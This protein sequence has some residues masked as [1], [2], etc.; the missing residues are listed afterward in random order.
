MHKINL[1]LVPHV[2]SEKLGWKIQT[3]I[4]HLKRHIVVFFL[5][6][7]LFIDF[8]V[9]IC[10]SVNLRRLPDLPIQI[11]LH[12]QIRKQIPIITLPFL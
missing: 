3:C 11:H 1:V 5:I 2:V 7:S 10:K 12:V 6:H 9:G 8:C 4:N